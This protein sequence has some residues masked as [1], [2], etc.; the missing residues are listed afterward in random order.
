[1]KAYW[2]VDAYIHVFLTSV[3]DGKGSAS[4]PVRFTHGETFPLFN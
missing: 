3:L 4:G 2:W 1:M